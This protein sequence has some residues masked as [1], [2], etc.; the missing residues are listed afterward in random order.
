MA[1]WGVSTWDDQGRLTMGP[2]IRAGLFK[3]S[4][5]VLGGQAT[6]FFTDATVAGRSTFY[7]VQTSASDYYDRPMITFDQAA[8]RWDWIGP[9]AMGFTVF[10]GVR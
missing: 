6:G 10:Y 1:V 4:F 2:A 8:G 9:V 5:S 7:L 3:G